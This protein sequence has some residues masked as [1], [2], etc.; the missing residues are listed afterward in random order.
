M[1]KSEIYE[2]LSAFDLPKDMVKKKNGVNYI[3]WA[4]AWHILSSLG[5]E[6]EVNHA[7]VYEDKVEGLQIETTLTLTYKGEKYSV[8]NQLPVIDY[9]NKPI[10]NPN[11]MDINKTR[12]RNFV[13]CAAL[14]GFGIEVY[15]GKY[16]KPQD[17]DE[18]YEEG[19]V[20]ND[21]F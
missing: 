3:A 2:A 19:S 17:N 16:G 5:Y 1:S 10:A 4:D 11:M 14:F 15:Q 7:Y 21:I 6:P 8:T 20:N 12:Q 13:K 9:K 18:L